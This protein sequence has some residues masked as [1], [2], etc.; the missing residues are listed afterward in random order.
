LLSAVLLFATV[1]G[2]SGKANAG[3]NNTENPLFPVKVMFRPDAIKAALTNIAIQEGYFKEE[4]LDIETIQMDNVNDSFTALNVGTV[5]VV[6][7]GIAQPL[8]FITQNSPFIIFGGSA[9]EGG[10]LIT[11]PEHAEEFKSWEN[12][13]GKTWASARSMTGDYVVRD[14]LRSFGIDPEK[15]LVY[16]DLNT[17]VPTPITQAVYKGT[18][19]VGYITSDGVN[20]AESMGLTVILR[21]GDLDPGYPC[22]RLI[23]NEKFL[24]EHRD[25]LVAYQRAVIRAFKLIHTDHEK[26]ITVLMDLSGQGK[27]YVE[28]GLY[29]QY[30]S[31]YYPNPAKNNIIKFYGY[32]VQEGF[33]TNTDTNITKYI[34]VSI[35]RE[36]L[37]EILK[38]H[39][40]DE[41][42]LALKEFSDKT[43]F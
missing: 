41:T 30:S 33:I 11:K 40:K 37:D 14:K 19:D 20:L 34:D 27:E 38:R 9:M 28:T 8:Q 1:S 5:D 42:Y 13:R 4:G 10:A 2:C 15:D 7:L 43:D 36:A 21:V 25:V 22:C 3:K 31:L 18:A 17:V 16:A 32:L 29:G 6:P 12:W 35:F 39:P 23:T 26:A 24:K